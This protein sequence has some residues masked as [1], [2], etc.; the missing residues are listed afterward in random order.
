MTKHF[1]VSV[2]VVFEEK[3]LL[4]L[5]KKAQMILPLGG[6]IEENELPQEACLRE[7]KEESGLDIVLYDP[8]DGQLSDL[9]Q[10]DQESLL[11]NPIHTITGQV[12][13]DHHHIDFVYYASSETSKTQP[14]TGESPHLGWYSTSDLEVEDNIQEN[15]RYLAKQAIQTISNR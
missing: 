15:I 5:H 2:F 7:A 14:Q 11:V 3:V 1:T 12:G 8:R 6:H 9:C 4:H 13:P 10:L